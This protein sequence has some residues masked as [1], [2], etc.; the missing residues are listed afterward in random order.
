MFT[1][2]LIKEMFSDKKNSIESKLLYHIYKY[3]VLRPDEAN[4]SGPST[5]IFF[6]I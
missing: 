5:Y 6:K 1:L 3:Y 4:R 2:W